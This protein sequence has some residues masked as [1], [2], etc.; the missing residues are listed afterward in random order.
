MVGRRSDKSEAT[1]GLVMRYIRHMETLR[2]PRCEESLPLKS[3]GKHKSRSSGLQVYCKPCTVLFTKE[4]LA[5]PGNREK[6]LAAVRRYQIKTGR[7]VG[8]TEKT[9]SDCSQ[10]YWTKRGGNVCNPCNRLRRKTPCP[11]CGGLKTADSSL[12]GDCRRSHKM[13]GDANPYWK[14]GSTVSRKGYVYVR[15]DGKYVA[16]HTLVMEMTLGRKLLPKEQVH[17]KNTVK[18]DNRI[19]NLELWAGSQPSGGRACDLLE[20]AESMV[21]I[22]GPLR[23]KGLL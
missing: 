17:H 22:Y 7:L 23:D 4:Y 6:H 1:I 10:V 14:G 3:F 8:H 9:C 18:D 15:I 20:W 11:E 19:E 2:C 12:C 5:I 16:E 13:T 21:S